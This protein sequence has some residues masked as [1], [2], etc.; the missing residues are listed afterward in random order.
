M[1]GFFATQ[2]LGDQ[3]YLSEVL[4]QHLR[5][6]GPDYFSGILEYNGW[7]IAHARL[8]IIEMSTY[9][10]QPYET[11]N[12]VL[13][14]N[15]EILNF[16]EL[17][18]KYDLEH[19]NSDTVVLATL[20]DNQQLNLE[21][22]EGFFSFIYIDNKGLLKYCAKDKF[23]VKP[24]YFSANKDGEYTICSEP[25]VIRKYL[26]LPVDP[27]AVEEYK[28]FRAPI[29]TGSFFKGIESV[30]PGTCLVNGKYFDLRSYFNCNTKESVKLSELESSLKFSITQRLI[31]DVPCGLL[32]SGGIDSN[33]INELTNHELK[34]FC[35]ISSIEENIDTI[36]SRE[37]KTHCEVMEP[38]QFKALF[39]R[40]L[41]VRGE[42]LSVPN[43][44]L[45]ANLAK[46]ARRLGI[47][48][49]LSGEAADEFFGGYDRIFRYFA[50]HSFDIEQ[51][52][53]LYCYSND[54]LGNKRIIEILDE[55]F[56]SLNDLSAFEKVRFFFIDYHLPILFRRLD[57][58][59]MFGGV[60]G[61]EPLATEN[62]FRCA[63]QFSQND[64]VNADVGKLPLRRLLAE[65]MGD[66]FAFLQKVGFPVDVK[67][68][69]SDT[70]EITSYELW[71]NE[72]LTE[73]KWL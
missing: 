69:F 26:D 62:I 37:I 2:V 35:S 64:L 51:F 68:I 22:L 38:D 57:F 17:A 41:R 40:M 43:E 30:R 21:E 49:L 42:P 67:K 25:I 5:F 1:C 47:K 63:M 6:R 34:R 18:Q 61:R 48:V 56:D 45:L 59:L 72:N 32:F 11:S 31:S 23:G 19:F 36:R 33:L 65:K 9:S 7:L 52:L 71:Q 10:N 53:M 24:L 14:Y 50:T 39:K 66:Q 58:A 70:S 4:E 16:K 46:T 3:K 28:Y 20:I 55:Y 8:S 29:I 15:G 12:G 54:I 60:E 13:L 27:N 73:L 44:V